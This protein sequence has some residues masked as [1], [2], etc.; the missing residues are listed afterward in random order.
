MLKGLKLALY[1]LQNVQVLAKSAVEEINFFLV[2]PVQD[3]ATKIQLHIDFVHNVHD[4][5]VRQTEAHVA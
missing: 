3:R 5:K 1:L 4:I 2:Y